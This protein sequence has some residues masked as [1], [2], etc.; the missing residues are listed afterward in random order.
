MADLFEP[1]YL[2]HKDG[3]AELVENEDVYLMLL[4]TP[5]WAESPAAFGVITAPDKEQQFQMVIEGKGAIRW[6]PLLRRLRTNRW[7]S[8]SRSL[9]RVWKSCGNGWTPWQRP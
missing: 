9:T 6:R 5:E 3:R 7:P 2:F 1:T 8:K 4:K